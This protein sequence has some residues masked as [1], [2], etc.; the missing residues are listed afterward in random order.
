MNDYS[1]EEEVQGSM[2]LA[3]WIIVIVWVVLGL[4]IAWICSWIW[5]G[6]FWL[7]CALYFVVS[8][9]AAVVIAWRAKVAQSSD[10]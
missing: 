10:A 3:G 2:R 9:I 6:T 7:V 4:L 5:S 8:V 1:D